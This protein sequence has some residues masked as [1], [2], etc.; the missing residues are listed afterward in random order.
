MLADGERLTKEFKKDRLRQVRIENF[1]FGRERYLRK[2][3]NV[4]TYHEV[5]EI[6]IIEAIEAS[7]FI[8]E[9]AARLLGIGKATMYRTIHRYGIEIHREFSP[10]KEKKK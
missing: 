4:Q 9:K 8:I 3:Q 10:P 2:T 6:A 1:K 7:G 5:K